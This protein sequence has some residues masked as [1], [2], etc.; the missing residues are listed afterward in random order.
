MGQVQES[1][2]KDLCYEAANSPSRVPSP[3][4]TQA[5]HPRSLLKNGTIITV[6]KQNSSHNRPV[7]NI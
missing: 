5:S 4:F 6:E 2:P 3:S 1:V 7:T